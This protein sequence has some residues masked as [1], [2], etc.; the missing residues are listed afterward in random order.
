MQT[1]HRDELRHYLQTNPGWHTSSE[2]A[3]AI[4]VS[5]RS[6]KRYAKD[7]AD[8]SAIFVSNKGY[9]Y[10]PGEESKEQQSYYSDN[11]L[12]HM[13]ANLL[14][15]KEKISL[16]DLSDKYYLSESSI[17]KLMKNVEIYISRFN[18]ELN[19]EGEFYSLGGNEIAKRR[20]I[21]DIVYQESNK[22][23]MGSETIQNSFPDVDVKKLLQILRSETAKHDV[24]LNSFDFNNVLLHLVIAVNRTQN[25]Y[26]PGSSQNSRIVSKDSTRETAFST[27]LIDKVQDETGEHFL[28]AERQS[29]NLMIRFSI[30]RQHGDLDDVIQPDTVRIVDQLIQYVNTTLNIDLSTLNFRDQ[31]AIHIQR[32]IDR[33]KQGYVERNPLVSKIRDSSPI[34]YECAVLLSQKLQQLEGIKLADDEIAYIAM[35]IGNAASEY[36][37]DTRKLYT[38]VVIPDYQ[39]NWQE[40]ISQ[41]ERLFSQDFVIG[42]VVHDPKEI[43][44]DTPRPINFVIQVN[45][46]YEIVGYRFVN[47]SQ[48]LTQADYK[49][50]SNEVQ[51]V[52]KDSETGVFQREIEDFFP[53]DNFCVLRESISR[54][55]LFDR[56]CKKLE[57]KRVVG[58]EFSKQLVRREKMS[59][60][61]FGRVAIPHS[62]EMTAYQTQ[63]Y[64]IISPRGISWTEKD[65]RVNLVFLLAVNKDNKRAYR[66]VFDSVSQIAVDAENVA[67]LVRAQTY[68]EFVDTLVTLI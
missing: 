28:P 21:S 13:V 41:L 14:T 15:T 19:R 46:E 29:L 7:L 53:P 10:N 55:D 30:T 68:D 22:A 48:F 42:K 1:D 51:Q 12:V 62:F 16:Y 63:G 27:E 23:F 52:R 2:L 60:T 31:F 36:M 56:V 49:V 17:V 33:S 38:V 40:F 26:L 11:D 37:A 66:N 43:N 54:D 34:I 8:S 32:L 39:S 6:I 47:I 18:L 25:G 50:I 45:T 9:R 3:V 58:P 59:S 61:A 57:I 44:G 20:M 67:K 5:T 35:H 65:S 24:Y 64:V 4:G